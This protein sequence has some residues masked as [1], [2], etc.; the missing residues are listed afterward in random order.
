LPLQSSQ[1]EEIMKR[2]FFIATILF[3]FAAVSFAQVT[4]RDPSTMPV[5]VPTMTSIE[6]KYEGGLFGY[7]T[8]EKG[9]LKFDDDNER[10]I[11]FGKD[12]KEKFSIPYKSMI[13]V[14]PSSQTSSSTAGQV[15]GAIPLPGTSLARLISKTSRYLVIQFEDADSD[16][17][18][19]TNFKVD[20]KEMLAQ[21]IEAIGYKAK[22][23]ARGD[24]YY[25]ERSRSQTVMIQ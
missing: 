25:R 24:A 8:K 9:M 16:A 4:P 6:V 5:K 22:M 13:V 18:G 21:T 12:Q 17:R 23:K 19:V 2:I 15:V 1:K 11:F 14:F 20:K 3:A 10:L 7:S